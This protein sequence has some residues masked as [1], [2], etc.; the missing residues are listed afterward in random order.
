M[1]NCTGYLQMSTSVTGY[2]TSRRV[3]HRFDLKTPAFI[4]FRNRNEMTIQLHNTYSR[5]YTL[6]SPRHRLFNT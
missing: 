4:P 3:L 5:H 2:Y 6:V 1:T